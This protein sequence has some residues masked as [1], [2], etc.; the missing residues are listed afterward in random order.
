[1]LSGTIKRLTNMLSIRQYIINSQ[2]S[3][4]DDVYYGSKE[5]NKVKNYWGY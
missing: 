3:H 5:G 4:T 1:M 2:M